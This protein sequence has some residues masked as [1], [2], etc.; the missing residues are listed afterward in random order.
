M[1]NEFESGDRDKRERKQEER[2]RLLKDAREAGY[3]D[4]EGTEAVDLVHDGVNP[5]DPT[6][7][8]AFTGDTPQRKFGKYLKPMSVQ[9]AEFRRQVDPCWECRGLGDLVM[10]DTI[11]GRCP[12]CAGTGRNDARKCVVCSGWGK[13][14]YGDICPIC[15]GRGL[16]PA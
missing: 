4:E 1:F 5:C 7:T 15:D 16:A 10:Y 2:L 9:E 13:S 8:H 12:T 11:V 6:P 3:F 14:I